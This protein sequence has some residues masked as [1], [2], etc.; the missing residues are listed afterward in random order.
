MEDRAENP[1]SAL[2]V[3]RAQTRLILPRRLDKFYYI[4]FSTCPHSLCVCNPDVGNWSHGMIFPQI[5]KSIRA[6]CVPYVCVAAPQGGARGKECTYP[7]RGCKFNPRVGKIPWRRAWQ[8]TPVFWPGESHA[9]RSLAG[10]SP[11]GRKET[12]TTERLH[13]QVAQ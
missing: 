5:H 13:F 8:P 3:L 11:W 2:L 1:V 10:C 6:S 9:Q 7:C 12:D 4:P